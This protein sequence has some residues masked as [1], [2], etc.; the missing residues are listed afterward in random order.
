[1]P[2]NERNISI[3]QPRNEF[4][5]SSGPQALLTILF[6]DIAGSTRLYECLGDVQALALV[7]TCLGKINETVVAYQGAVVKTIGDEVMCAFDTPDKAAS[8]AVR[9][10]EVVSGDAY[11][12]QHLIRLRIGLHHGPVITENDDYFGDAVNTAARMVAMAKA[13]QII[14]NRATLELMSPDRHNTARLVD[15]TQVKGKHQTF[16]LYELSWGQPEEL[17]MVST[18]LGDLF[19]SGKG[20]HAGMSIEFSGRTFEIDQTQPVVS[21]GRDKTNHVVVDDP[22]VSRLH[23]RIEMRR[24]K[25]VLVDQ[26]TNGTYLLPEN[27][28]MVMLRRDEAKLSNSGR[29]ALGEPVTPDSTMLIHYRVK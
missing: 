5:P 13:G 28:T 6:A 29:L 16:D 2:I 18:R 9:M 24:N 3:P 23:A 14:T 11:L 17:T 12:A 19:P 22:K 21:M 26:S 8:A 27:G 4:M 1:M 10:H 7:S 20:L 25:F 15:Q